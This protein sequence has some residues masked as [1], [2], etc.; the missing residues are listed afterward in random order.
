MVS[1]VGDFDFQ[2]VK[3][4]TERVQCQ[5]PNWKTVSTVGDFDFQTGKRFPPRGILISKLENVTE[6]VQRQ[7]PNW[8]TLLNGKKSVKQP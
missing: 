8:K 2:T 4:V 5:F 6:R 3:N 1:T 7:F